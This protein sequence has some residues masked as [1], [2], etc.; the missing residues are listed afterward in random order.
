LPWTKSQ[1]G[2]KSNIMA[3]YNCNVS[4]VGKGS[5]SANAKH[6]YIVREGKYAFGENEESDLANTHSANMP[7]W[8]EENPQ[9]YWKAADEFS[10]SNGQVCKEVRFAL[11][12]ELDR[13]Q[14]I[15]LARSY[16]QRMSQAEGGSHPYTLGIHDDGHN[17][18]AHLQLS[19][20]IND[21]I[22]REPEQWFK[23]YNGKAPERGGAR[24]SPDFHD[25]AFIEQ[26]R[27]SWE[28]EANQALERAGHEF[29]ISR[30]TLEEQGIERQAQIHVGYRDPARPE[31]HA[32]RQ[33]RNQ[34]IIAG[35][36][37]HAQEL[38]NLE[39]AEKAL[40]EVNRELEAIQAKQAEAQAQGLR[41][42]HGQP[43]AQTPPPSMEELQAQFEQLK[44]KWAAQTSGMA[45]EQIT[46]PK[47]TA[48]KPEQRPQ[49]APQPRQERPQ[50]V[51]AEAPK[52]HQ[53]VTQEPRRVESQGEQRTATAR[54]ETP[55]ATPSREATPKPGQDN[56]VKAKPAEQKPF[57]SEA[58]LNEH[59]KKMDAEIVSGKPVV[60]QG[61]MQ[62]TE[63]EFKEYVKQEVEKEEAK[64]ELGKYGIEWCENAHKVY[65]AT[66]EYQKQEARMRELGPHVEKASLTKDVSR[67]DKVKYEVKEGAFKKA[68]T[69]YNL[70]QG[71]L[72][73]AA[74][75]LCK[76]AAKQ[77]VYSY[78]ATTCPGASV[79]LKA[80]QAFGVK[81][82][83]LEQA[84]TP[85]GAIK[86]VTRMMR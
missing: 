39:R 62:R 57:K 1:K 85:V 45:P 47:M 6:Q 40:A 66:K 9:A 46:A 5:G 22:E 70:A 41:H 58:Q 65:Q 72:K 7:K 26:A 75:N 18:H 13:E 53:E 25:K 10:R 56:Q 60:S 14:Q 81:V 24:R 8:A 51:K 82:Q 79:A 21:G 20:S 38:G 78:L 64:I 84:A 35:N 3:I 43:Q 15:E 4:N 16:A 31:I 63:N 33:A 52:A 55:Q 42:G 34:E 44:Q 59:I 50:E 68:S 27:L 11:P 48:P 73:D 37:R 69:L 19:A 83:N 36:I 67:I 17:P 61:D 71:N 49:V 80:V 30:L 74:V 76:S 29:Q 28:Q 77:A 23:R 86:M 12:R 54:V 32:A 2:K